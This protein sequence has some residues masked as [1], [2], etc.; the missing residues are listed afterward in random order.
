MYLGVNLLQSLVICL[1]MLHPGFFLISVMNCLGGMQMQA[2]LV[3]EKYAI[4]L[5]C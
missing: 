3:T 5:V 4:E 1:A 2:I